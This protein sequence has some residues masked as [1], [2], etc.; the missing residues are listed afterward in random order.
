MSWF[1]L[2]GIGKAPARLDLKKLENLSGQHMSAMDDA[3]VVAAARGLDRARRARRA[4]TRRASLPAMP[5]VKDARRTL[6]QLLERARFALTSTGPSMI[7][8]KAAEGA[9]RGRPAVCSQ[10]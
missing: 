4:V 5:V 1:E 2:E 8:E 10:N 6:P 7:D 9:R 3:D